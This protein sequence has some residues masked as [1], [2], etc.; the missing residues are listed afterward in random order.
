[1]G[2]IFISFLAGILTVLS[3]C[4][5][6]LLPVIIGGSL[7][8]V[9][10]KKP[11][12]IT[13]SL[14]ISIILF[15]LLLKTSSLLLNVSPDFWKVVS[16]GVVLFFGLITLFPET[17]TKISYTLGFTNFS[18]KLLNDS[19]KKGG[20]IGDILIGASLGPVFASCSPTYGIIV[21][22]VLPNN[23]ALGIINL[24]AYTLG[25]ALFM[26]LIAIFGQ[27][28]IKKLKFAANPNGAFRKILGVI[29]I[30]VGLSV[31]TGFDKQVEVYLGNH[32]FIDATKLENSILNNS[33]QMNKMFNVAQPYP[34]EEI[35]GNDSWI[36]SQPLKIE[37]LKGKVV[38]I[39]FW[40]YS[41]IN[42]V[43][44]L[45]YLNSWYNKY[46]D[47]G[48]VVIGVHSP[49]FQ[50]EKDKNNVEKAV[51]D[52]N[53]NYP[54]AQDNNF[55]T[56]NAYQNK[57]WP[58]EYFID[59][60]GMVRHIHSGEGQYDENEAIIQQLLREGGKTIYFDK[61]S[62]NAVPYSSDQTAETYLGYSRTNTII[63]KNP[64][65]DTIME[66]SLMDKLNPGEWSVG[67]SWK[68]N[69]QEI[70][71]QADE[72][73]LNINFSAKD[74]YLVMGSDTDSII[75][76]LVNNTSI[77][78]NNIDGSDVDRNGNI[79]VKDYKLYKVVS[80][81]QFTANQT[82]KLTFNKNIKVNVFT[83]GS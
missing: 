74:V 40:T 51:K 75:K 45:P 14:S 65:H 52:L 67:G 79:H 42:C 81:K 83:F 12:I 17:W 46:K 71:S 60:Q 31:I 53:V 25:L 24:G 78:A 15:T 55:T 56:W 39:D 63:N 13:F 49:E 34:A 70:I 28:V 38:L 27:R 82:L 22:T 44:T 2:L 30:I 10:R 6:P 8:K 18:D 72:A 19:A 5:L 37:D 41:C 43:R 9:D 21:A 61:T 4:V 26:L 73:T 32:N 23:L 59:R 76:V 58:G 66:Y 64:Q 35:S 77:T 29:F 54:V 20:V 48:F 80:F 57:Y 1:M 11:I 68:L 50:F 62:N 33:S 47:Y 7:T 36:N 3:P 16:G 69:E